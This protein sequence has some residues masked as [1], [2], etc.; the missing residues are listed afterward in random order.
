MLLVLI[1]F[2]LNL[3]V[4]LTVENAQSNELPNTAKTCVHIL[5][6]E[7]DRPSE[8]IRKATLTTKQ[9]MDRLGQA[10]DYVANLL[11]QPPEDPINKQLRVNPIPFIFPGL[12][13]PADIMKILSEYDILNGQE[14]LEVAVQNKLLLK[15][16]LQK[17][18]SPEI[19]YTYFNH[20]YGIYEL[21]IIM[22]AFDKNFIQDISPE[23]LIEKILSLFPTGLIVKLNKGSQ[24][25]EQGALYVNEK[26]IEN[27]LSFWSDSKSTSNKEFDEIV[28]IQYFFD[29]EPYIVEALE[30]G[31]HH[32]TSLMEE[33]RVHTIGTK[34]VKGAT[35]HR[36]SKYPLPYSSSGP[37]IKAIEQA[38]EKF[39][40]ELP[41][42]LT[43]KT[44]L[45]LDVLVS[46]NGSIK[47]IDLNLCTKKNFSNFLRN[48]FTQLAVWRMIRK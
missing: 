25:R 45:G 40:S 33:Y 27:I 34:V 26:A 36:W 39:L 22:R 12:M 37:K 13:S 17:V 38:V 23:D 10:I 2:F 42:A 48:P 19:Y 18:L 31:F 8:S 15:R 20:T 14:P 46:S 24:S 41:K 30:D 29:N 44:F 7:P 5:I 6:K 1:P 3:T 4:A 28:S 11:G 32:D 16:A 21:L 35:F 47:I 43:H 9:H